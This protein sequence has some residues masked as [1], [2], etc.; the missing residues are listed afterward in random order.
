MASSLAWLDFSEQEQRR[1]LGVVELFRDRDTIDELG[2]GVVRDT[3]S[4]ILFPGTSTLHSRGRYV[5]FIPWIYQA[6]ER[7]TSRREDPWKN[8]RLAEIRLIDAL[9]DSEDG[10]GTI[11]T[12]ARA[13][14]KTFASTIY[15]AALAKWGIRLFPLSQ[16]HYHRWLQT[17]AHRQSLLAPDLDDTSEVGSTAWH[18]SLPS[19]PDDFPR[20][21]SFRFEPYESEYVAERIAMTVPGTLLALLIEER[22]DV[23]DVEHPWDL[24]AFVKLPAL[25][26]D[27][28]AEAS[29]FSLVI[30]GAPLLYNLM[31]AEKSARPDKEEL[32]AD[33]EQRLVDWASEV[34][35]RGRE[36]ERWDRAAFWELIAEAGTRTPAPTRRFIERWL[37]LAIDGDPS[38]VA[39]NDAARRLITERER[40]IKRGRARLH[41]PQ[42]L[43]LWGGNAGTGRMVYRWPYA[44]RI[45]GDIVDGLAGGDA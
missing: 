4:D 41:S 10:D 3:F 23:A 8:A 19:A 9:L 40:A 13:T 26:G 42:A 33:F 22:A 12:F 35:A 1:M 17:V 11:G 32:R 39:G 14:L 7:S 44:Q 15:W 30:N 20:G 36:L 27:Q 16:D 37:E 2:V 24:P 38:G 31:L 5:L 29:R 6:I 21:V 45:V 28:L 25:I 34:E 18:A 43:A